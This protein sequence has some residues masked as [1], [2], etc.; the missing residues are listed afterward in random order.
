MDKY[1]LKLHLLTLVLFSFSLITLFDNVIL[2]L[3][4]FAY[5]FGLC[6]NYTKTLEQEYFLKVFKKEN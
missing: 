1:E 6:K 2:K 4:G 5:I 3:L